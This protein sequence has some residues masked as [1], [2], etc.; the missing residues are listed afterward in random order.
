MLSAGTIFRESAPSVYVAECA[1]IRFVFLQILGSRWLRRKGLR[2]S[3]MGGHARGLPIERSARPR[4]RK[5]CPRHIIRN[6]KTE[7]MKQ[8]RRYIVE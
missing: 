7:K 3:S 6:R 5:G 2:S 1:E 8:R 4:N